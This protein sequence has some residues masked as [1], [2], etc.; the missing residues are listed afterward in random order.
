M[1][2]A[3]FYHS[4]IS[5]WNHGNAHFLRG[6]ATEL[7]ARGH[8]VT[9]FEPQEGW[10]MI[11][12]RREHGDQ[13]IQAFRRAFPHLQSHTYDPLQPD[14]ADWLDRMLDHVDV[15]IVHEWNETKLIQAIGEHRQRQPR[16]SRYRLLF[17]DTHHRALSDDA[18]INDYRLLTYD[19]VLAFGRV[20]QTLYLQHEWAQRA[21]VWHEAADSS[22]FFPRVAERPEGDLVWIGNWG[23][24]ER[25]ARL[26]EF[27]FDP[28]QALDLKTVIYGVRYPQEA[29]A[30]LQQAGI[31][32][33]GWLPNYLAPETFARFR[34]T[35]HIPRQPYVA[36]LPGIPTIRVFEALACGI[37]LICSPWDD[38]EELFSAGKDYQVVQN[39]KA[40]QQAMRMLLHDEAA[41]AA[42]AAHGRATIM[43][44]HTCAHRV[45]ELLAI[46]EELGLATAHNPDLRRATQ[47][48]TAAERVQPAQP[49]TPIAV[50][51]SLLT[52]RSSRQRSATGPSYS[53]TSVS[54]KALQNS[55]SG[56]QASKGSGGSQ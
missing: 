5:D 21:W 25:S 51:N 29:L 11:N 43:A 24:N 7:L 50:K 15:T 1:H 19:G 20:V 42:L 6:V 17:H 16:G 37:P 8:R 28:V 9:I 18:T 23:D 38:C 2:F 36:A 34:L 26:Q 45:D 39:G 47:H 22:I 54:D 35:V 56:K 49:R 41:A 33:R 3:L 53:T 4:L 32:Y 44:R 52:P 48:V 40:M 31:V 30:Q 10:S 46:C 12:L 27:L 14:L 55:S 13:A